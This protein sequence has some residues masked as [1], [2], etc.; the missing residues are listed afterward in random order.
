MHFDF[1]VFHL[2]KAQCGTRS[3]PDE[4]VSPYIISGTAAK[5][6]AWP[7]QVQILVKGK[8]MCGGTILDD[9]MILTA[10]HCSRS[11]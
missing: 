11:A 2:D 3:F 8:H 9:R 6:G 4:E 7:W 1:S 5:L 10:A